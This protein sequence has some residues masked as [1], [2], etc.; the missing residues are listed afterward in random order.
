MRGELG[1]DSGT[2]S[3]KPFFDL[4][5]GTE[6]KSLQKRKKKSLQNLFLKKRAGPKGTLAT[7]LSK[8]QLSEANHPSWLDLMRLL[9]ASAFPG[10]SACLWAA[11]SCDIAGIR[12]DS[13][14][15]RRM[16]L[17][18]RK[19]W[20]QNEVTTPRGLFLSSNQGLPEA[21][22]AGALREKLIL[23]T[24]VTFIQYH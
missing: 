18:R 2:L 11:V 21:W 8:S 15:F 14:R 19:T 4:F 3:S 20:G 23:M 10:D 7:S 6:K 17:Q 5:L 9:S 24:I 12:R 13:K 1:F 22:A 16:P